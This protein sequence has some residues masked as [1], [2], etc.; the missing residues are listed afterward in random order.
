MAKAQ[1]TA[2]P[3]ANTTNGQPQTAGA[4]AAATEKKPKQKIERL[5]TAQNNFSDL[6]KKEVQLQWQFNRA[7]NSIK[8][9]GLSAES[10]AAIMD[11]LKKE[12]ETKAASI[13]AGTPN[14]AATGSF[15]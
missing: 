10:E 7:G 11:V 6:K 1:T 13:F 9:M 5:F 14:A 8:K 4:E 3:E 12:F 2:A 15:V